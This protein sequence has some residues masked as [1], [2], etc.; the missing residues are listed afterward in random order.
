MKIAEYSRIT[1]E[2]CN[3]YGTPLEYSPEEIE[4]IDDTV[5]QSEIDW[6][7]RRFELVKA[8]MQGYITS[9]AEYTH[10]EN[11]FK[12]VAELSIGIA[13]AVLAEYMKGGNK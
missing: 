9:G 2:N 11:Q 12:N 4:L 5:P 10:T 7:Q 6:E 8:A 1:M 13:D 3:S